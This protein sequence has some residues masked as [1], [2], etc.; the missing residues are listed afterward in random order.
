MALEVTDKQCEHCKE[1]PKRPMLY[2]VEL[3][4]V[5]SK[6]KLKVRVCEYCD[7]KELLRLSQRP[8]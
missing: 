8:R 7:G 4:L 3:P 1:D 5:T 6:Q 2:L